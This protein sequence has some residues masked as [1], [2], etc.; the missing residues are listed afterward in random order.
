MRFAKV[1]M[2][3]EYRKEYMKDWRE[4]NKENIRFYNKNYRVKNV[5]RIKNY[6]GE[7]KKKN[8]EKI[9]QKAREYRQNNPEIVRARSRE[10]YYKNK[11]KKKEYQ[12]EWKLK[13]PDYQK[14]YEKQYFQKNKEKL[15]KQRLERK[16][17]YP[18]SRI[19]ERLKD[20]LR[21]ALKNFT[22]TGKIWSSKKYGID[23]NA[24]VEY[25]KPLPENLSDYE[26]HHIKPLFT[27]NFVNE[28]GSTNLEEVRKAFAPENHKLL[29]AN[30][31]RKLNH[32][33]LS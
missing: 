10:Q 2:V 13:N 3:S 24:I 30:E 22:E 12:K 8:H 21:L 26:I 16:N 6:R 9:N 23:Y 28:D 7:Y 11:E 19:R 25:L 5:E 33:T 29:L 32:R 31:H 18:Y 1:K 14:N 4:K 15:L 27:F 17:K 20:S